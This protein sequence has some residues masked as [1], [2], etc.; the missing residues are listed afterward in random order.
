MAQ[1]PGPAGV[2]S[3]ALACPQFNSGRAGLE[4]EFG[5]SMMIND[6]RNSTPLMVAVTWLVMLTPWSR[7]T[8]MLTVGTVWLGGVGIP[9]VQS[10]TMSPNN[11]VKPSARTRG[12]FEVLVLHW[13][14]CALADTVSP[15]SRATRASA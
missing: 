3:S 2:L 1:T 5:S 12:T 6:S 13:N 7:A 15:A 9:P 4:G 8:V 14:A 10:S 11:S